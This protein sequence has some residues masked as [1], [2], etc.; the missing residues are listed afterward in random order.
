MLLSIIERARLLPRVLTGFLKIT[1]S[2]LGILGLKA[3]LTAPL[4]ARST[5]RIRCR[6][7]SGLIAGRYRTG[8]VFL[9]MR[10]TGLLLPLYMRWPTGRIVGIAHLIRAL[11]P[12]RSLPGAAGC[13]STFCLTLGWLLATAF[14]STAI[15]LIGHDAPPGANLT[16]QGTSLQTECRGYFAL[17]MIT[18]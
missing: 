9:V 3:G 17:H 11:V 6:P 12:I 5:P 18:R 14:L 13:G 8:T 15:F 7:G 4:G 2:P 1:Q 16:I 10:H